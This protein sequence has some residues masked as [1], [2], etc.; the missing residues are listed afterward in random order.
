MKYLKFYSKYVTP[1]LSGEKT[2]TWRVF[3]EKN[4]TVGDELSLI[5]NETGEVFAMARIVKLKECRFKDL[6][7]EDK[8][9]HETFITDEDMYNVFAE[10]YKR[11]VGS[12]DH[13]KI[14]TFELI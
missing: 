4:L 5:N 2:L 13:L 6:T 7:P 10:Y 14:I 11:P 8:K 9:A 1:I 3:D 12:Q